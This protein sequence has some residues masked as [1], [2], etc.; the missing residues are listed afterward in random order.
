M[1]KYVLKPTKLIIN[2]NKNFRNMQKLKDKSFSFEA[3]VT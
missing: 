2:A 1:N 3:L